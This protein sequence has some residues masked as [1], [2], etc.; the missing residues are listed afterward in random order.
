MMAAALTQ[1][2]A[3]LHLSS[4]A[5]Q[6]TFSI[7]ILG[8]AFAPF[9]I[10]ALSEMYGRRSIWIASN[11]FYILWNAICPV[12]S[13]VGL[14]TVGRFLAGSDASAGITVSSLVNSVYC[15]LSTRNNRLT[16]VSSRV[17]FSRTCIG[18]NIVGALSQWPLSSPI[19]VPP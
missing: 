13:S 10:E 4:T 2:G 5:T 19:W 12:N 6:I 14:M 8:L 16:P 1:I 18:R 11:L 9:L 3:D 7:F 17:P 15:E